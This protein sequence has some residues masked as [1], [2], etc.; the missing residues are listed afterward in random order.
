[1]TIC[2]LGADG[3]SQNARAQ[4]PLLPAEP[5]P[6]PPPLLHSMPLPLLLLRII[7]TLINLRRHATA[8]SAALENLPRSTVAKGDVRTP[9]FAHHSLNRLEQSHPPAFEYQRAIKHSQNSA[10]GTATALRN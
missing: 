3:D 9:R 1:M 10:V 7:T 2:Q 4:M 6:P 8:I 5:P